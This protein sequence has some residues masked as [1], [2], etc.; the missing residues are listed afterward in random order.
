MRCQHPQKE[1][2]KRSERR[3][4]AAGGGGGSSAAGAGGPPELLRAVL[5]RCGG[6]L[7]GSAPHPRGP[8]DLALWII[9]RGLGSP[10]GLAMIYAHRGK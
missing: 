1:H 10:A 3:R 6:A 7:I 8:L 9:R 2:R 4:T 5:C